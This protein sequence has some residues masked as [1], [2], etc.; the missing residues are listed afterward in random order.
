M[1]LLIIKWLLATYFFLKNFT[2]N[3]AHCTV[4]AGVIWL[5]LKYLVNFEVGY[6]TLIGLTYI[7]GLLSRTAAYDF[8]VPPIPV[9]AYKQINGRHYIYAAN[10]QEFRKDVDIHSALEKKIRK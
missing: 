9:Y 1:K 3:A 5:V 7:F 8:R 6:V 10:T 4:T 2:I